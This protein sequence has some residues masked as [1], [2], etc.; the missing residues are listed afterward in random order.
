MLL[1]SQSKNYLWLVR[2]MFYFYKVFIRSL[3]CLRHFNRMDAFLKLKDT[4]KMMTFIMIDLLIGFVA[5]G[6]SSINST[7]NLCTFSTH[8]I[9]IM[10][11]SSTTFSIATLPPFN[12]F[13]PELPFPFPTSAICKDKVSAC[14]LWKVHG[15]I[16]VN[17]PPTG[18]LLQW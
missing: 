8:R 12:Y 2:I 7:G 17:Y 11:L 18:T 3:R 1:I 5:L 16:L 4:L 9:C 10:D 13:H 14:W 15:F 6:N